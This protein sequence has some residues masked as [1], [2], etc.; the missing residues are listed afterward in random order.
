MLVLRCC[1]G[2]IE[3][4]MLKIFKTPENI[5]IKTACC[6]NYLVPQFLLFTLTKA[7][8]RGFLKNYINVKIRHQF[9]KHPFLYNVHI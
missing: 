9:K 6:S 5:N 2:N 1:T 3:T 8:I 4:P 7:L